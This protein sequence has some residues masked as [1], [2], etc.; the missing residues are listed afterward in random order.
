MNATLVK[1]SEK[2]QHKPLRANN[3][4]LTTMVGQNHYGS[5]TKVG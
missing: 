2:E 1:I 3:E 4:Q 5:V